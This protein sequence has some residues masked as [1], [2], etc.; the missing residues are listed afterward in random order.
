MGSARREV[1]DRVLIFGRPQLEEEILTE[2]IDH[3]QPRPAAPGD[4]AAS[5][6]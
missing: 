1:L 4:R 6:L 3:Y 2:F 5:T